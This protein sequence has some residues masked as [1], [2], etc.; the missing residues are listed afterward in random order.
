M[1]GRYPETNNVS[2][3]PGHDQD[4][5]DQQAREQSDALRP[6]DLTDDQCLVWDRVC[7]ELCKVRRMKPIFV[8]AL[9]EY[10]IVTSTMREKRVFLSDPENG[11]T[12]KVTGR[13]GTQQKTRPEVAHLNELWRQWNS[14]VS[15]FGL[16]PATEIRFN[17][18]QLGL[19]FDDSW[20]EF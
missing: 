20:N 13:N 3:L 16:S 1:A 17:S 2:A 14:L 18:R 19:P 11:W 6:D 4:L 8:D 7:F 15:Q 9:K 12:Y 5:G 10:C